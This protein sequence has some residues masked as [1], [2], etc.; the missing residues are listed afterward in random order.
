MSGTAGTNPAPGWP[1]AA[2]SVR[3]AILGWARLA[4]Q[5]TQGSGYNLSASELAAGLAMSGHAVKYLSSGR[6]YDLRPWPHVRHEETWRGV[7]CF[8][9]VNSRNLSPASYNFANMASEAS[10]PRDTALVLGWL[11]RERIEIVHVHSL[12]GFALDVI[13]RIRATGRPVV[14]TTHNYWF[15]CPQVDL[16]RDESRLCLDYEGGRACEACIRKRPPGR[17]RLKR[18]LGQSLERVLGSELG[19]LMR[20]AAPLL[21]DRIRRGRRGALV[22][23]DRAADPEAAAGFEVDSGLS[24]R[25][26][27]EGVIEHNLGPEPTDR[28]RKPVAPTPL[29]ANESFLSSD[30]HLVVLN[31]YGRRRAQGIDALNQASLVTPPSDFVRRAYVAMGVDESRTRVV[32]LGQPHFDQIRRRTIRGP[33]YDAR[34]WDP[35]AARPVRF[36]FFGAMRPSKGIDVLCEA[37]PLLPAAIRRRCQFHIRAMGHDWTLRKR[38]SLFPEVSFLGGYDLVQLIGAG[39]EYDVGVLPHAWFENSPLVLL[40]HLHAGKFVIS[41]RLGGPVEWV[42]PPRNGLMV[43]GGR[44]DELAGAMASIVEGRVALPSPREVHEATPNV[45]SYPGHVAEVESIYAA[46]LEGARAPSE[47]PPAA[48]ATR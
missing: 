29:D 37:I 18:R 6:T 45:Q 16:M 48:A 21:V 28:P 13:G 35:S 38:L 34:P 31:G 42:R 25:A 7:E 8:D 41:S 23:N 27:A 26:E 9:L 36:G 4:Y 14:V 39:A 12:E 30:R 33:Y 11:D 1:R 43:A 46:L 15:A 44:P 32:R 20:T 3:V 5:G 24:L 17:Q 2:R 19:G 10:S 40:E 22:P 47:R